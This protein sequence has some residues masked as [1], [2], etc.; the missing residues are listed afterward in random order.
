MITGQWLAVLPSIAVPAQTPV[1]VV[2]GELP[3][4]LFRDADAAVRA[5]L[6]RCPHRRVPLS[7]GKVVN[8]ALR[9]AYHGWSFAGEN[10]RCTDIP[11]VG[12]ENGVPASFCVDAYPTH[13]CDGLIYVWIAPTPSGPLP[14][15]RAADPAAAVTQFGHGNAAIS[16]EHY[17]AVLLDG[18][19]LIFDIPGVRFTD[20]YLGDAELRHGKMVFECEAEWGSA[21]RP[22]KVKVTD[23][24]LILRTELSAEHDQ[25]I[26]RLLSTANAELGCLELHFTRGPRS[27]TH[28]CWRYTQTSRHLTGRPWRQKWLTLNSPAIRVHNRHDGGDIAKLLVGPSANYN[29]LIAPAAATRQEN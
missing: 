19:E 3:V 28:Y 27:T 25:V 23:R 8:G 5:L 22:A 14:L 4:V 26:F 13:E 6:D 21:H 15:P 16:Y 20:F 29:D 10:G 1:A 2:I 7:L 24:P 12:K 11:N 9:C 18:P 17:R